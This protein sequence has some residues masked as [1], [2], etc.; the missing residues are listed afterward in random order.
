MAE[1]NIG[2]FETAFQYKKSYRLL[3]ITQLFPTVHMF[4]MIEM[5]FS[6][7]ALPDRDLRVLDVVM[8]ILTKELILQLDSTMKRLWCHNAFQ[9]VE[10]LLCQI[11][12]DR[13]P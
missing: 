3:I 4:D 9:W 13:G 6:L 10:T 7:L 2:I 8:I 11:S 12:T 5:A 1:L